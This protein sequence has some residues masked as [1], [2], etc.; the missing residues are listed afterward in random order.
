MSLTHK[1]TVALSGERYRFWLDQFSDNPGPVSELQN[2]L[3]MRAGVSGNNERLNTWYRAVVEKIE[4]DEGLNLDG[5]SRVALM[6]QIHQTDLQII[7]RLLKNAEGDYSLDPAANRF[8]S[9]SEVGPKAN[10]AS[11]PNETHLSALTSDSFE[12]ACS[13]CSFRALQP[14]YR[15]CLAGASLWAVWWGGSQVFGFVAL[16]AVS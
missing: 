6:K 15:T 2:L 9:W 7:A 10:V 12:V 16:C 5:S 3:E 4:L 8:P 13:L 1:Q 14:D 11:E